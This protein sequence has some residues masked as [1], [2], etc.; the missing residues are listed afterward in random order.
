MSLNTAESIVIIVA[1]ALGTLFTRALPFIIFPDS[2]KTPGFI[3]YL[4]HVLPYAAIAL[5]IVYCLKGIS[6][7]T[8]PYGAPEGIAI[9][10]IALF[11][12]WKNNSLLSIGGGT[13][14]YM[15]LVQYVFV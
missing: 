9:I 7:F 10:S 3:I 2:K 15:L 4:G 14:L 6:I 5:L 1:I 11:H 13:V 12:N 8:W